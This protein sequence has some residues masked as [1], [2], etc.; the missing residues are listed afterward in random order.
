MRDRAVSRGCD[1]GLV[2]ERAVNFER[3]RRMRCGS[4]SHEW[5][6][7]GE[8]LERFDQARESC[9]AC[10]TDCQGE[11]RPDFC[12]EPN[13]PAQDDSAA[14]A[15][16]WY[17]SST[18]ERWPDRDFDPSAQ[19]T[20]LTKQRMGGAVRVER[21]AARQRSRAL[22]VGTY[23]AA[24]ENMFRRM[25]DQGSAGD[26]FLLYRVQL[27]D[28]SVIE[29]GVHE[30]PTN[31]VGDAYL[32]DVCSPGVNALRYVNV[33]EDPSSVSLAVELDAIHA[34]QGVS[35]PLPVEPTDPW[36]LHATE[37]L[38][39]AASRPPAV[40]QGK[41]Q[42]WSRGLPSALASAARQ[43]QQEIADGLPLP[44]RERFSAGF[45]EAGFEE[46]PSAFAMK[47]LGLA[48]LVTDPRSV[49]DALDAQSWRTI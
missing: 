49:L 36:V 13:D 8:W 29:P 19:L 12:A 18:H 39:E 9:P 35:I 1:A 3:L 17:H 23:E 42:R 30:E 5:R 40:P 2:S 28:D 26:T 41:L 16:Y 44:L 46:V 11:D 22:H 45:D 15:F 43:L 10:G 31:F 21:W 33:H 34:V 7:S 32:S 14:R 37:R 27:R 47:L 38:V 20:S 6:V 25:S 4:C 24:I 48:R